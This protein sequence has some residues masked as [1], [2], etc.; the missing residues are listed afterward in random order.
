MDLFDIKIITEQPGQNLSSIINL[1][2]FYLLTNSDTW[3]SEAF[4][5]PSQLRLFKS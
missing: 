1:S 2:I 5:Q 3:I 4:N